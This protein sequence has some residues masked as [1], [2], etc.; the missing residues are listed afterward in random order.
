MGLMRKDVIATVCQAAVA[1]TLV[2]GAL[3]TGTLHFTA[4]A[5][6]LRDAQKE[7]K[8]SQNTVISVQENIFRLN[9]RSETLE[10]TLVATKEEVA[11]LEKN[12]VTK[13]ELAEVLEILREIR[14]RE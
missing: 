14:D 4:L 5:G 6:D 7:L 12:M 11:S 13:E 8:I 2:G 1:L 10:K 3:V 9:A